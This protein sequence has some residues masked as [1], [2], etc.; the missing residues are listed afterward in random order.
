M[1]VSTIVGT[2]RKNG[3][4]MGIP[5]PKAPDPE[6]LAR[7]TRDPALEADAIAITFAAGEAG[8]PLSW[9]MQPDSTLTVVLP[10]GKKINRPIPTVKGVA[11]TIRFDDG[12]SKA[13]ASTAGKALQKRRTSHAAPRTAKPK[14]GK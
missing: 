8:H 5:K 1:T 10:S 11:K 2:V 9:R 7:P 13:E 3:A 12:I 14:K 4:T 6:E